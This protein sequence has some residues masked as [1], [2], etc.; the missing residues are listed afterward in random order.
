MKPNPHTRVRFDFRKDIIIRN[1]QQ[2]NGRLRKEL[3]QY[4]ALVKQQITTLRKA[5]ETFS[6]GVFKREDLGKEIG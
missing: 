1:L 3:A 6:Q 5:Q 4:K 2:E